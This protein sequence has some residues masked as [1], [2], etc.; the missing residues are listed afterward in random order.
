MWKAAH[1]NTNPG[2]CSPLFSAPFG[3]CNPLYKPEW[4]TE[5]RVISSPLK[6]TGI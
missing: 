4:T 1:M 2:G 5:Q 6:M 3:G